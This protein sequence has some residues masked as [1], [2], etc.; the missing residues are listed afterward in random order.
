MS[1]IKKKARAKA[2]KARGANDTMPEESNREGNPKEPNEDLLKKRLKMLDE[3]RAELAKPGNYL[4]KGNSIEQRN[5]KIQPL[6]L[7]RAKMYSRTPSQIIADISEH[8]F[9]IEVERRTK[10]KAMRSAPLDKSGS[11]WQFMLEEAEIFVQVKGSTFRQ[12]GDIW[13]LTVFDPKKG[14]D[15]ELFALPNFYFGMVLFLCK[16]DEFFSVPSLS[17]IEW[18]VLIVPGSEIIE[19]FKFKGPRSH[20]ISIALKKY[21]EGSYSWLKGAEDLT[22]IFTKIYKNKTGRDQTTHIDTEL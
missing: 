22:E 1:T 5:V 9:A 8:L 7:I 12:A 11:D 21:R 2:S 15:K 10:W 6:K 13:T 19:Y 14:L 17:K 16:Q 18:L 3:L 4:L 20:N